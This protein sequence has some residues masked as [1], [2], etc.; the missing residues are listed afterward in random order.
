MDTRKPATNFFDSN[1]PVKNIYSEFRDPSDWD[2]VQP[3]VTF[4]RANL[5]LKPKIR[6][7]F[8]PGTTRSEVRD[9][10]HSNRVFFLTYILHSSRTTEL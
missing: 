4:V 6:L 8:E 9:S 3:V 2:A 10:N 1:N 7:G 5:N